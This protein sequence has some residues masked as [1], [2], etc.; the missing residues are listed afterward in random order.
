M[1]RKTIIWILSGIAAFVLLVVLVTKVAVEP[2]LE[3][4]IRTAI[5]E[6]SGDYLVEIESV[7]VSILKAGIELQN[8][9]LSSKAVEGGDAALS[10]SIEA[11]TVK[12]VGLFKALV[13]KAIDISEIGVIGARFE[14]AYVIQEKDGSERLV[15]PLNIRVDKLF[16]EDLMVDVKD[17]ASAQSFLVEDGAFQLDRIWVDEQDSISPALIGALHFEASKFKT[18]T[19]DSFY[20]LAV[21]NLNYSA[22]SQELTADSFAVQPNY[23]EY[24]F[25]SRHEYET[26]RFDVM[27]SDLLMSD[28]SIADYLKSDSLS[29]SYIEMGGL[30]LKAFRDKR[31]EF[32]HVDRPTF[33][34]E[35]YSFPGALNIDSIAILNGTIVYSEHAEKAGE[36]GSVW[37]TEVDS[38][39]YNI[40]NDSVYKSQEAY[41]EWHASGLLM[42][43]GEI[44][45]VLKSKIYDAQNAFTVNGTLWGMEAAALNPILENNAFISIQKG[46]IN[47]LE[48]YIAANNSKAAGNMELRYRGLDF[49]VVDKQTGEDSGFLD[50]LKSMVADMIVMDWNPMPGQEMRPGTIEYERDPEKFLFNYMVKSLT[51]GVKTSITKEKKSKGTKE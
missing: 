49:D 39:L 25:T 24:G 1:K 21:V 20:T 9:T 50:Q 17:G 16:F 31:E 6:N 48:F 32:R 46:E 23:S 14:G 47:G 37:F 12:G 8:I 43:A 4:K 41:L 51:S 30:D 10:G 45:I 15:S 22:N 26:D 13:R 36:M 18:V 38:R 40:T 34:E 11:L 7:D 19:A 28:L 44:A 27:V 5:S 29:I 35:I 33:Q 42:G 2:W 3:D